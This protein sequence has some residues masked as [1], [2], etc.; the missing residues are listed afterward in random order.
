[1]GAAAPEG[2][3]RVEQSAGRRSVDLATIWLL[4]GG[5]IAAL[6]AGSAGQD[7]WGVGPAGESFGAASGGRQPAPKAERPTFMSFLVGP[8]VNVH[9]V[10]RQ[11]GWLFRP[12]C[13]TMTYRL[14]VG[15]LYE[16]PRFG[17]RDEALSN[18]YT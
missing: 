12:L 13:M 10:P 15:R 14:G 7:T 18:K 11:S 5:G 16:P 9:L 4:Y 2:V 1:M 8:G 17:H 3:E 6:G